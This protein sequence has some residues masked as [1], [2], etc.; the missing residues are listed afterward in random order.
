MEENKTETTTQA[1][2]RGGA[3]GNPMNKM[4]IGAVVI[5]GSLLLAQSLVTK[6]PAEEEKGEVAPAETQREVII[7]RE[8]GNGDKDADKGETEGADTNTDTAENDTNEGDADESDSA[9]ENNTGAAA[10]DEDLTF[11][12]SLDLSGIE[13][14]YAENA[15]EDL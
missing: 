11:L 13:N 6:K 7:I 10:I 15:I 8:D 1:V 2:P 5:L 9:E 4:L 12:D 14:D 3:Q